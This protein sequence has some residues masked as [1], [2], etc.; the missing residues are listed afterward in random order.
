MLLRI[1]RI[2]QNNIKGFNIL[3]TILGDF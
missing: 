1:M 3:K 2:S